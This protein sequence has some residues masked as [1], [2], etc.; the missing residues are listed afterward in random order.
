MAHRCRRFTKADAMR[1]ARRV[2]IPRMVT[3]AQLVRGMNV[4][5]E[6]SDVVGCDPVRIAKIAAA[7][8]RERA[9]YYDRLA[10]YVER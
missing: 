10:R 3:Y 8:L 1:V 4:E 6:H 7:H 5:R 2:G 9:D